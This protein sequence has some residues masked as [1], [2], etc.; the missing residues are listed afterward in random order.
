MSEQ[1]ITIKSDPRLN[2]SQANIDQVYTASKQLEGMR[3]V[4]ADAV[5]QLI[6]S[7]GIADDYTKL[8]SKLDKKTYEDQ[9]KSSKEITKSI[10]SLVAIY[11]GKV[12]KRQGITRN[13]EEN[14]M[15]RFYD[16]QCTYQ[17]IML[18]ERKETAFCLSSNVT[19]G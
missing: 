18:N 5:K 15:Q 2:I 4:A 8:L 13:P 12:D 6:E 16:T 14:V 3:Q 9:I 19:L 17:S 10:D 7:K 11:L 1:M